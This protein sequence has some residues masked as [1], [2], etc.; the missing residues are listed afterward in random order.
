MTDEELLDWY[1]SGA[2]IGEMEQKDYELNTNKALNL[3][4]Q[5][6]L[7]NT[8]TQNQN[9]LTKA[10]MS[11][12]QG[13][14]VSNEMLLK[15]IQQAQLASGST[16]GQG[17]SDVIKA[18]NSYS[19]TRAQINSDFSAQQQEMLNSY[20]QNK[21]V[22]TGE[23]FANE[24]NILDKYYGRDYQAGRDKIN[25]D[26]YNT[27]WAYQVAENE[28]IANEERLNAE[29]DTAADYLDRYLTKFAEDGKLDMS[30]E[31]IINDLLAKYTDPY[32]QGYIDLG[33]KEKGLKDL[34]DFYKKGG[35]GELETGVEAS[36][37][38]QKTGM[39]PNKK[40]QHLFFT[41]GM[42][43]SINYDGGVFRVESEGQTDDAEV[44]KTAKNYASDD[45][46]VHGNKLYLKT[47]GK[48]YE[49]GGRDTYWN[50]WKA[51]KQAAGI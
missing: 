8:L 2:A 11:A 50:D 1:G 45:I 31:K 19:K 5:Q 44:I 48:V 40:G 16:T 22:L 42:L 36:P 46:F 18:Q 21:N 17:A 37:N 12:E 4:K 51:L 34:L 14:S 24:T 15:Y 38:V 23:A 35:M 41:P 20:A 47:G 33:G 26:R 13:A 32:N 29:Y 43:F 30:E 39:T 7:T 10:K 6:N 9:A 49:V 27:E 28:R 3:Q 25:D